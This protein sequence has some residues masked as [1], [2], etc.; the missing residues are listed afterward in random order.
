MQRMPKPS[1][2]VAAGAAFFILTLGCMDALAANTPCSGKKGGISHCEGHAFI[3]NDGSVSQSKKNCSTYFSGGSRQTS[4]SQ[5]FISGGIGK[6]EVEASLVPGKRQSSQNSGKSTSKPVSG[7]NSGEM[8]CTNFQ[9]TYLVRYD[10]DGGRF[11]ASVD[12]ADTEYAVESVQFS[13]GGPAFKG[14]TLPGGPMFEAYTAGKK[15]IKF[16]DNKQ[17]IQTDFCR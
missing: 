3:C 9:R 4:Q 10:A 14:L 13:P 16:F 12:E 11:V 5:S 15:R 1:R 2:R 17:H 8:V 6:V 7:R